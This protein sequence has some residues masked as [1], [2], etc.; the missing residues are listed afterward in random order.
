MRILN[1]QHQ[2]SAQGE[3]IE[4]AILDLKKIHF[5][6][7]DKIVEAKAFYFFSGYKIESL[8]L[9]KNAI[10]EAIEVL[11]EYQSLIDIYKKIAK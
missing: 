7:M 6:L 2:I 5:D 9:K 3:K 1:E 10:A 11:E 8:I 4:A